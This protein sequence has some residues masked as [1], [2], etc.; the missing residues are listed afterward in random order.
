MKFGAN[1]L[2]WTSPFSTNDLPLFGKVKE[3]GFDSIEILP[4]DVS[5]M[6]LAKIRAE[7]GTTG[8]DCS[9]LCAPGPASDISSEYE[10]VQKVGLEYIELC[11]RVAAELGSRI[12]AGPIYASV[13]ALR[14][15]SAEERQRQ[16]DRSAGNLIKAGDIARSHGVTLAMEPINRFET[17]LINTTDDVLRMVHDVNSPQ[18]K[19]QLDTF[20]LNIEE[21][22]IGDAIR[23]AGKDLV[24]FH[25]CENDRGAPGSGLIPWQEVKE[26][27]EEIGYDDYLVIESFTIKAKAIAK[28]A[29]IWRP[30][31]P[32]QDQ[33]AMDGLEFLKGLVA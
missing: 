7:L 3:M 9:I 25:A 27:L 2:I 21:K 8:L 13:G 26:A 23:K 5:L 24:H 1:T 18:V 17:D 28:A 10:L 32:S 4:E 20:H 6:D 29:C 15:Y 11:I 33:L 19:V 22:S 16:W 30:L 14:R 31:A 12:V